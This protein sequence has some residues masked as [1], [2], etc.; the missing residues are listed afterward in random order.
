VTSGLALIRVTN[1]TNII[2]LGF[3]GTFFGLVQAA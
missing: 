2:D 1:P 3:Q